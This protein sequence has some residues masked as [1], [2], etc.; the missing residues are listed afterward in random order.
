MTQQSHSWAYPKKTIIQRDTPVF[1]AALL[2]TAGRRKPPKYPSTEEWIKK[3]CYIYT[4]EY[5][6]AIKRIK[7]CHL[8]QHGWT[9]RSQ[10]K[11]NI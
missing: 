8:Q 11:T 4:E 5:Y 3:M 7:S 6:L 10:R 1:T 2:T 9:Y